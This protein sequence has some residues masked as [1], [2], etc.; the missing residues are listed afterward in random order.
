MAREITSLMGVAACDST[1]LTYEAR[2][3]LFENV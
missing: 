2:A 1:T 3:F